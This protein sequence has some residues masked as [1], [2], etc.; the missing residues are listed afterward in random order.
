MSDEKIITV[1]DSLWI[2][3]EDMGP[4]G[5]FYIRDAVGGQAMMDIDEIPALIAALNAIAAPEPQGGQA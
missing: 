1:S 3:T 5:L 4:D 2:D